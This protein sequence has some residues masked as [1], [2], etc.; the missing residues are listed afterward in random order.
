M[1]KCMQYVYFLFYN[2]KF[3]TIY[4]SRDDGFFGRSV[5][6]SIFWSCIFFNCFSFSWII[7]S[8]SSVE[9]FCKLNND[10]LLSIILNKLELKDIYLDFFDLTTLNCYIFFLLFLYLIINFIY[11]LL[12]KNI[13][14]HDADIIT[15]SSKYDSLLLPSF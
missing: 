14:A 4:Y 12:M 8:F 10:S 15:N 7:L 6:F 5:I 9:I 3:V 13:N 1:T 2:N 11:I